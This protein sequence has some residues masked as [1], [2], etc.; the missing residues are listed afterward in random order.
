MNIPRSVDGESHEGPNVIPMIDVLMVLLFFFFVF[1]EVR[2]TH[3][4]L[5]IEPPHVD[6]APGSPDNSLTVAIT[7][8]GKY[9]IDNSQLS[10]TDLE[11]KLR[12]HDGTA[13]PARVQILGDG[14]APWEAVAAVQSVCEQHKIPRRSIAKVA[15][16]ASALGDDG[17]KR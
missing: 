15:P 1:S 3:H 11:S 4:A 13:P 6:Y 7:Q 12:P 14:K 9:L 10:L 8:E 17:R 2:R 5:N 16:R